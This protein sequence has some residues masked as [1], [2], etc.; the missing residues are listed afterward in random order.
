MK[1][2]FFVY[3]GLSEHSGITKKIKAQVKGLTKNGNDVSLCTLQIDPD[4]VQKRVCNGAVI[5]SFGTG[6]R[7]KIEKRISYKDVLD[8]VKSNGIEGVYIRYDINANPFTVR[9]IKKLKKFGAV[10]FVEIPTWP[11][12]G[13]FKRQN[14][15]MQVQIATDK[16]FRKRFFKHV[17]RVVTCAPVSTIFNVPT[18]I[19]SNGIDFDTIP[20]IKSVPDKDGLRI[21]SV[22]NIH[23]WHG[24]DRLIEGMA[25]NPDIPTQLHIV[26]DGLA[27]IIEEY[28]ELIRKYSLEDK[29][30]IIGPLSG[31]ALDNE[32]NWA[33]IAAGSLGRHRSG[34]NTIKTLKNREYAARGLAFFY[35][36]DDQDFDGTEYVFKMK[37]DESPADIAGLWNFFLGQKMPPEQIRES[38]RGLSWEAQLSGVAK[39]FLSIKAQKGFNLNE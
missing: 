24:L 19:N 29:V 14:M 30:K 10:V 15:N 39:C 2:L 35:S 28:K 8:Y 25:A 38:V 20:L 31:D 9:F 33:N 21:L 36:E 12:D 16:L 11:Y 18:I 7:S 32:F 26:G 3:H 34:I 23:L 1:I 13:E 4:G 5:K 22:A 27:D 37:A 6:L 17:D